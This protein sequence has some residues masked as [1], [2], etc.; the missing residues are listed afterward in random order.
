[1]LVVFPKDFSGDFNASLLF[2]PTPRILWGIRD[3]PHISYLGPIYI[4]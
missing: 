2:L 3:T 4:M 1:M